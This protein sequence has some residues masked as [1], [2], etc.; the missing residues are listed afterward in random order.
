MYGYDYNEDENL[1]LV[2]KKINPL[3]VWFYKLKKQKL[4]NNICD[5]CANEFRFYKGIFDKTPSIC[6]ECDPDQLHF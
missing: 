4:Y 5:I 6:F 3:L 1:V 2:A